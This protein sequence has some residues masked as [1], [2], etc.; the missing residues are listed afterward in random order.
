[1]ELYDRDADPAGLTDMA[2]SQV[3]VVRGLRRLLIEWLNR[4]QALTSAEEGHLGAEQMAQLRALGY[5]GDLDSPAEAQ[6]F[7][8]ECPCERCAPYR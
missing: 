3:D 1:M 5:T 8:P 2:S 6:L 7:D 4:P